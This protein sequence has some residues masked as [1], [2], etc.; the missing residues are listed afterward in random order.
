L[1]AAFDRLPFHVRVEPLPSAFAYRMEVSSSETFDELLQD[2]VS[3]DTTLRG[4]DLP[5]GRYWVR[6]RAID[7]QGLEG[8]D[9]ATGIEIDARPE[10]PM[11]MEPIKEGKV[12]EEAPSF[13]WT[14]PESA[15]A[16]R[17]QLA[18]T[19]DLAVP[20]VQRDAHEGASLR[21]DQPLSPGLYSWRVA[22]VD[23]AGLAGPYSDFQTFEYK[24]APEAPAP[25]PAES[26]EKSVVFRW[27]AGE[28]GQT[29]RIQLARDREFR[30]IV[31]DQKSSVPEV[32][33]PRPE[34]GHYFLRL[35]TIEADGYEGPFGA[36]QAVDIQEEYW[37][38]VIRVFKRLR[39]L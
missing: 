19:E 15:K 13:R 2:I 4:P 27:R 36:A 38:L 14:A 21:L 10:P 6:V 34:P 17:F 11:L 32:S 35:C 24:P 7:D 37:G 5:D 29:Y 25:G 16:Y 12:R 39:E 3:E 18:K 22:T 33:V 28:P 26:D 31:L 8:R 30:T 1:P 23:A 20:V 9:T